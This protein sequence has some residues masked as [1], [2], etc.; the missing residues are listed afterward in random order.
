MYTEE[1]Q[2]KQSPTASPREYSEGTY[3]IQTTQTKYRGVIIKTEGCWLRTR[4]M[5]NKPEQR[6]QEEIFTYV[7]L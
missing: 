6:A 2:T 5:T 7:E 1:K 4:K 3:Q